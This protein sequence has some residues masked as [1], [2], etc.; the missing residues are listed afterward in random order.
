MFYLQLKE[1]IFYLSGTGLPPQP[2]EPTSISA[3]IGQGSSV[4]ISFKNP[5][6]EN[7]LVDVVLTGKNICFFYRVWGGTYTPCVTLKV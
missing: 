7:V 5:T 3:C 2:M 1:W 4:K 6:P